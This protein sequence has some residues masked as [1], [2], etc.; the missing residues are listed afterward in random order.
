MDN[1]IYIDS[2][3]YVVHRIKQRKSLDIR[4]DMKLYLQNQ[5]KKILLYKFTAHI[6]IKGNEDANRVVKQA[7]DYIKTTLYKVLLS[8][9]RLLANYSTSNFTLKKSMKVLT[10]V[11]DNIK[12]N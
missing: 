4:S 6:R 10:T 7:I 8:G 1:I 12:L 11:V 3:S 2:Q 9:K 5:D